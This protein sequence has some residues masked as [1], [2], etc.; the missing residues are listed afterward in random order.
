MNWINLTSTNQLD[1][2]M[3]DSNTS[4]VLIFK[5]ST[6]CSISRATLDRLERNWGIEGG[7][8]T[9]FLDI[10]SHRNISNEIAEKFNVQHESPQVL[11]I[12]QGKSVYDN[13][14]FDINY[15]DI[16]A[17]LQLATNRITN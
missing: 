1:E 10:L 7:P 9:Y 14:H 8:K 16:K 4:P 17:Q 5:H 3:Q 12:E 15:K 13:S 2:L 6:S 11:I